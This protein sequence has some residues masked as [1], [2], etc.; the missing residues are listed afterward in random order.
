MKTGIV[1]QRNRG[2]FGTYAAARSAAAHRLAARTMMK[3][4]AATI[5]V[6]FAHS[7]SVRPVSPVRLSQ[8]G[9]GRSPSVARRVVVEWL[10]LGFQ[11][12][13]ETNHHTRR[14]TEGSGNALQVP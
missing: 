14:T 1:S 7:A 9:K 11:C 12:H 13:T 4:A 6:Q 3:C 10:L 5:V 8:R 2:G